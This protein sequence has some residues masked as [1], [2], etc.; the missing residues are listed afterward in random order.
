MNIKIG[1]LYYDL[2]NL[3][4][5][6]GNIKALTYHLDKQGIKYDIRH[7]S[8][9]KKINFDE[10]DI[11][12]IG[13]GTEENRNLV[14][15]DLK[16]YKKDIKKQIDKGKFF[17]VTGNALALFGNSIDNKEALKIFDFDVTTG[18]RIVKEV[19]TKSDLIKEEIY[20]FYNHQDHVDY[21]GTT[22][23]FLNDGV[24][25]NNFYGTYLIGPLL[26]RNPYFTKYFVKKLIKSKNPNFKIKPFNTKLDIQAYNEFIEFKK[27]K[28]A[29]K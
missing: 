9:K 23:L 3:Y 19:K 24:L 6:I 15:E 26:I 27:N 28:K 29:I 5:E 8:I 10:F 13:S 7:V 22:N 20:G 18:K 14:L 17:L 16:K 4:G 25:Y 11:I 1:Y 12:Y 2:M 21:K